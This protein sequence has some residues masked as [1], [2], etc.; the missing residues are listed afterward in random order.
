VKPLLEDGRV[1]Y[2]GSIYD[3]PLLQSYRFNAR[4]LLHGHASDGTNPSLLESMGFA[5]PVIAIGTK[6]N[7]AVLGDNDSLYFKDELEMA[8]CINRLDSYDDAKLSRLGLTNRQTIET[9]YGWP[10]AVARHLEFFQQ[11]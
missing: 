1:L 8:A 9:N 2:L 5:S 6:S 10:T 3:R 4:A 7:A 11:A